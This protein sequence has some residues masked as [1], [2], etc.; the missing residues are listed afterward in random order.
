MLE[1]HNEC[2]VRDTPSEAV[3]LAHSLRPWP[4]RAVVRPHQLLDGVCL[5][6]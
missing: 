6:D 5:E 2:I 1:V 3:Q 4:G